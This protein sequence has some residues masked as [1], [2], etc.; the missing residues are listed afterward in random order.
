MG[1]MGK[2]ILKE[3]VEQRCWRRGG[4]RSAKETVSISR[5][6]Q[7]KLRVVAASQ[8]MWAVRVIMTAELKKENWNEWLG[9]AGKGGPSLVVKLYACS[10][11]NWVRV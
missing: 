10:G 8:G 3:Y 5:C 7:V 9:R 11:Y 1:G 2:S 4:A 6:A